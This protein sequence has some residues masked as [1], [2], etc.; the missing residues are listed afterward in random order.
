MSL[1]DDKDTQDD[2]GSDPQNIADC[3]SLLTSEARELYLSS[4]VPVLDTPPSPLQ[5][6]RDYVSWN[7][8]V[9]IRNGLNHWKALNLWQD[10]E[11]FDEHHGDK[12]V[13]VAVTPNGFADSPVGDRFVM[14]EERKIKFRTFLQLLEQGSQNKQVLYIQKQNSNLTQEF[15]DL[16]QQVPELLWAREA[17][18]QEPDAINFWMGDERAVTSMHKDPYENIYTVVK[19]YKDITLHPPTDIAWIPYK[20]YKPAVY[21]STS[22]GFQIED[23]EGDS[24]PWICIDPLNP[25]IKTYPNYA[26][27]TKIQ[28]RVHAGEILYLPSLWFHHLKQSH[29][30]ISVNFWY[31]MAFDVKYN[32]FNF[33]RNV[34]NLAFPS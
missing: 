18:G 31:D 28:V 33:V 29:G 34:A 23:I 15:P 27:A 9:L 17:F 6:Y 32:Y 16:M 11:Y 1:N 20:H 21:K 22:S 25:D 5:F 7:R 13:S 24:V 19:G 4:S 8:P 3:L 26:K 10:N 30:C 12:E 2:C 14:P